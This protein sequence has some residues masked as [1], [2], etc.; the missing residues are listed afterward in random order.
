MGQSTSFRL[1]RMGAAAD[2]ADL[3]GVGHALHMGIC[4]EFEVDLVRI[5]NEDW[6]KSGPTRF[7]KSP[8]TSWFSESLP[9]ENA[10]APEK[11]VVMLQG[12]QFTHFCVLLF[13][14]E[15]FSTLWPFSTIRIFLCAPR[16]NSSTAVKM[17]AGPAPTMI[18]HTFP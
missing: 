16:R 18:S 14:Q 10:P 15:R 8:P 12:W 13:G 6:A 9:S 5:V 3:I 2:D 11:P 7:G 4:A 1:A 17:P